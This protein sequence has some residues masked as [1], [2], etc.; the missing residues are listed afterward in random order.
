[1]AIVLVLAR[2]AHAAG[3]LGYMRNGRVIGAVTT[4]TLT[5][6]A[7]IWSIVDGVGLRM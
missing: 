2:L 7:A 4:I 3:M 5:F 6:V 1:M